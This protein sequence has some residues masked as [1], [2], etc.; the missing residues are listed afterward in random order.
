MRYKNLEVWQS[1]VGLSVEI[2][3]HFKVST[4]Y[5]FKDQ[6]T[7]SSLSV[8]SSIAEGEERA[9]LKEQIHFLNIAK[10]SAGE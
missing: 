7:R 6:I 9:G 1:S 8:P 4:D 5:D 10:G 3:K 2:Y